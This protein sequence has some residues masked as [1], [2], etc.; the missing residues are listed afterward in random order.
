MMAIRS[1]QQ[2]AQIRFRQELVKKWGVEPGQRILEIGCGQGDMT[3]ALADA[4]GEQGFVVAVDS[5]NPSY[6]SPVSIGDSARVLQQGALG[7]RVQY[8]HNFDVL[9]SD[10]E[11]EPDS[12]DAVVLAH[13]TWYFASLSEISRVLTRCRGWSSRLLLSEWDLEPTSVGQFG[14]WLSVIIQGQVGLLNDQ[15]EANVRTPFSREA[16]LALLNESGWVVEDCACLE[17][18]G[19]ADARWEIDM[20]LSNS[21]R[22]ADETGVDDKHRQWLASQVDVLR[23][24]VQRD[25]AQCLPAYSIVAR[26]R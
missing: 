22:T 18:S 4:I 13:C 8:R 15:F 16:M 17:S 10:V 3:V 9:G 5:A 14:H 7:S 11:F 12:F 25:G 2:V 23:R 19:L 21:L 20:C 26:R 1:E 24:L 6:G